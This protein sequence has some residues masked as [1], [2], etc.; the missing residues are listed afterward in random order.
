MR[1][2]LWTLRFAIRNILSYN[3]YMAETKTK[4]TGVKVQDFI[5]TAEPEERRKDAETLV[6]LFEKIT[7]EKAKMWGPSIIGFGQ[8]HYKYE[9]GHE[10]DAPRAGFSPRKANL[11]LYVLGD[12]E[13]VEDLLKKV[14][15]HKTGKVCLY[16]KR[17]ADVDMDV[18]AQLIRGN[19]EEMKKRYP[20]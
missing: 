10:G 6:A 19:W 12:F 2:L 7:G 3:I 18:I 5:A 11:V 1:K 17:L 4:F 13:G 9:S 16:I 15:K 20:L 8:Y 14:G